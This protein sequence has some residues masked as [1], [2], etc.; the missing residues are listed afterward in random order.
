MLRNYY[1]NREWLVSPTARRVYRMSATFTLLLL[2][3]LL[4]LGAIYSQDTSGYIPGGI[5]PLLR[6]VILLGVVGTAITFVGMEYFLFTFDSS[7]ALTKT[8]WF[9]AML[10]PMLGPPLYCFFIYL[11]TEPVREE[12]GSP[13]QARLP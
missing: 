8:F 10:V 6:L 13:G 11:R 4:S 1:I 7:S 3:T 2:V 9:C 12:I 5:L